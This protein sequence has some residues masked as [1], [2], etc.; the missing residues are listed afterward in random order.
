[1]TIR[2]TYDSINVDISYTSPA[3]LKPNWKQEYNQNTSGSGKI[4]QINQ[5][6]LQEMSIDL[7]LDEPT[8]YD[9]IAFRSWARQ[10]KPFSLAMDSTKT[11]NSTLDDAAAAGQKVIPLTATAGLSV[12]DVCYIET[13]ADDQFE[14]VEVASISAGVSITAKDN[15]KQAYASGDKLRHFKYYPS[16]IATS[17]DFKPVLVYPYQRWTLKFAEIKGGFV[18]L[19]DTGEGFLKL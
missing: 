3:G 18:G 15:L 14:I 17:K 19:L 5:Y 8:Y 11:F 10:G 4:E 12:D 9:M 1:M 13:D 6:G 2:I 7:Y 16:V